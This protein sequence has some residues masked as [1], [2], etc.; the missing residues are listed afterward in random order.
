MN[1]SPS[2]A[3]LHRDAEAGQGR[4]ARRGVPSRSPLTKL[5]PSDTR[6]S[7]DGENHSL[8]P[9]S[10]QRGTGGGESM[11]NSSENWLAIFDQPCEPSAA[12]LR[13]VL[14]E[15]SILNYRMKTIRAGNQ[16]EVE[17]YPTWATGAER[18]KAEAHMTREVQQRQNAKNARKRFER[19]LNMNF[20][21]AD[22]RIDCTYAEDE[23]PDEEQAQLD[24]RNYLRCVKA[25]CVKRGFPLPLY[26]GVSEGKCAGSRQTRVHHH[27]VISCGLSRDDLEHLWGKGRVRSA[28]LQADRF[29]YTALAKYLMKA[30]NGAKR[31]FCSRNLQEPVVTIADTRV[32]IR[33]AD[34][35]AQNTEENA[36]A[37]FSKLFQ[38]CELLNCEVKRSVFVAGVYIYT[39]LRIEDSP[40]KVSSTSIY[41]SSRMGY[42]PTSPRQQHAY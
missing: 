42:L 31:Y 14:G 4:E 28:R 37:I 25:A 41:K 8:E 24:V 7:G 30:P 13:A 18:V 20:T 5:T 22:Y 1:H 6:Q 32:S 11:G 9:A 38:N 12:N 2:P 26:M 23:L 33:K 35:L 3:I 21:D 17:I 16:I 36:P 19:K 34:R 27:I 15:G 10:P 39:R 29:G 40:G